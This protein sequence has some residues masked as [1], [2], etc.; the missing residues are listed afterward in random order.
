MKSTTQTSLTAVATSAL[1]LAPIVG[2]NAQ[3]NQKDSRPN[4]IFIMVDDLG[5]SD[6]GC[7]GAT[8]IQTPNIDRLASEGV[9]FRQF[10][11]N[12]ISAPPRASLITGQYQHNAGMGTQTPG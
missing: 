9:R 3:V 10:Y 2:A 4:I 5:F 7:Y 8:D 6:L 1:A 11:N 12:T